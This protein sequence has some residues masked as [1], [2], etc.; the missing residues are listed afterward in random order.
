[1]H[2]AEQLFGGD[3]LPMREVFPAVGAG[4]RDSWK[5]ELWQL[6]STPLTPFSEASAG[7]GVR[8]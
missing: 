8:S 6:V 5:D 1:M 7:S 3:H 2:E 4:D